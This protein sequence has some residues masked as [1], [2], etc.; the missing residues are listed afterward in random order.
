MVEAVRTHGAKIL[1]VDDD[2]SLAEMLTIVLRNEGY[3]TRVCPTGDRAL[4]AVR[5]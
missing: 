5:E 3:D 1:V 4:E 2:S